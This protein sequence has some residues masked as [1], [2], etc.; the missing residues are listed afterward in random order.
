[1][2]EEQLEE[3]FKD[4]LAE[5]ENMMID[6]PIDVMRKD[7]TIQI[8]FKIKNEV[9]SIVLT[10]LNSVADGGFIAGQIF[11]QSC[12]EELYCE[13]DNLHNLAVWEEFKQIIRAWDLPFR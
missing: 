7:V 4:K 12:N 9:E 6:R 3:Y 13:L 10:K 8:L 1:M 2:K 11:E 5:V